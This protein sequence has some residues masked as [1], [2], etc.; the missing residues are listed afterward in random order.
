MKK[1]PLPVTLK[2][3]KEILFNSQIPAGALIASY[4]GHAVGYSMYYLTF[5]SFPGELGFFLEDLYVKPEYQK[6]GIGLKLLVETCKLAKKVGC[7]RMEWHTLKWNKP[8]LKFWKQVGAKQM[9]TFHFRLEGKA[10]D[11]LAKP[12]AG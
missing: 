4:N 10:F 2:R 9:E 3:I 8:T 1:K 5:L 7:V 11:L 6:Q 12:P